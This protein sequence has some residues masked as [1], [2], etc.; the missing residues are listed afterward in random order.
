MQSLWLYLFLHFFGSNYVRAAMAT[1]NLPLALGIPVPLQCALCAVQLPL[2][3]ATAGMV[4]AHNRQAFACVSHFAEVE[5][6]IV[7]WAD[8]AACERRIYATLVHAP[9]SLM[10]GEWSQ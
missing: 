8:F 9:S 2:D 1:T 5:K 6:L 4:D 7:G 10:Y 3:K